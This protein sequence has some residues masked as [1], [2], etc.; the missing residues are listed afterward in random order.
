MTSPD[1]TILLKRM[2]N[3]ISPEYR[4]KYDDEAASCLEQHKVEK[5]K[6]DIEHLEKVNTENVNNPDEKRQF[7]HRKEE[8]EM[9]VH[10][11]ERYSEQNPISPR[12][13]D[14][15][16]T[17]GW[18][19]SII[20][21]RSVNAGLR[22]E[23]T[24]YE[25]HSANGMLDLAKWKE[26]PSK[27]K[28]AINAYKNRSFS[29]C[30]KGEGMKD[31][32]QVTDIHVPRA[33]NLSAV[34]TA[35]PIDRISAKNQCPHDNDFDI[36]SVSGSAN[37]GLGGGSIKKGESKI[38]T[39]PNYGMTGSYAPVGT[40][41]GMWS[42]WDNVR[43]SHFNF[44]GTGADGNCVSQTQTT[45]SYLP[46]KAISSF[47]FANPYGRCI[48]ASHR[49][50]RINS[51][52][53]HFVPH[54]LS[55]AHAFPRVMGEVLPPLTRMNP[56]NAE[57]DVWDEQDA[58]EPNEPIC[59]EDTK[60]EAGDQFNILNFEDNSTE[61]IRTE[62][63]NKAD[64][65]F[66]ILNFKDMTHTGAQES[67]TTR[68]KGENSFSTTEVYNIEPAEIE[69]RKKEAGEQFKVLT[70][71]EKVNTDAQE[72]YATRSKDSVFITGASRNQMEDSK[73]EVAERFDFEG[74]V[75]EGK[76]VRKVSTGRKEG[77]SMSTIQEKA[78]LSQES[79]D[80][81]NITDDDS[82]QVMRNMEKSKKETKDSDY[83]ISIR[84][85]SSEAETAVSNSWSLIQGRDSWPSDLKNNPLRFPERRK[86]RNR[87]GN[88][89]LDSLSDSS[90][91][92]ENDNNT[93]IR[94]YTLNSDS[95]V[96]LRGSCSE[97]ERTES[98]SSSVIQESSSGQS[99]S[100][101]RSNFFL[102]ERNKRYNPAEVDLDSL[103]DS[104][105]ADECGGST[106][107]AKKL[108]ILR[109]CKKPISRKRPLHI[110]RSLKD[111]PE[112]FS[113]I[114]PPPLL[115]SMGK[116]ILKRKREEL[117]TNIGMKHNYNIIYRAA[118]ALVA[119]KMYQ[120]AEELCLDALRDWYFDAQCLMDT[121]ESSCFIRESHMKAVEDISQNL[122][123]L[124]C[125]Y[126]Q[127][128]LKRESRNHYTNSKS[129]C[130]DKMQQERS[131]E[132]K[133][134]TDD[135]TVGRDTV[136]IKQCTATQQDDPETKITRMLC[137]FAVLKEASSC[138]LAGRCS[139]LWLACIHLLTTVISNR[140]NEFSD[141]DQT[142][143]LSF[144]GCS[145]DSK[146]CSWKVVLA[147]YAISLCQKG[148]HVL[149]D[150]IDPP[151]LQNRVQ[152]AKEQNLPFKGS[153]KDCIRNLH[154]R[155]IHS[156]FS[157]EN[158]K[159]AL[160]AKLTSFE[161]RCV[162]KSKLHHIK[163][164]YMEM[165]NLRSFCPISKQHDS[166]PLII[167]K[168]DSEF[169][170]DKKLRTCE[171]E[172]ETFLPL[173][174]VDFG[175]KA[176]KN[177]NHGRC[178][179]VG[180][181]TCD[182]RNVL[183]AETLEADGSSVKTAAK[184]SK[185][186]HTG[187]GGVGCLSA[188]P[189]ARQLIGVLPPPT[190]DMST[191]S[192]S[193]ILSVPRNERDKS[194][195]PWPKIGTI[196]GTP[197][198]TTQAPRPICPLDDNTLRKAL[199]EGPG[200][201]LDAL[202]PF[203]RGCLEK[204]ATNEDE[205]AVGNILIVKGTSVSPRSQLAVT[206]APARSPPNEVTDG[207]D[208]PVAEFLNSK[209]STQE[210]EAGVDGPSVGFERRE[211]V[212]KK[213]C[214]AETS[215]VKSKAPFF[216]EI[217]PT[218][219]PMPLKGV[220]LAALEPESSSS[221][222][223]LETRGI[224][225]NQTLQGEELLDAA[226][227]ASSLT[228]RI[229]TPVEDVP[230]D[231]L[232]DITAKSKDVGIE[233][234]DTCTYAGMVEAIVATG[235]AI[236]AVGVKTL[237]ALK[238]PPSGFDV[239]VGCSSAPV[240]LVSAQ[241]L[242]HNVH[243][244]RN[245]KVNGDG[246]ENSTEPSDIEF[247]TSPLNP[248]WL[249]SDHS[250]KGTSP[251]R[252][253]NFDKAERTSARL[254]TQLVLLPLPMKNVSKQSCLNNRYR[255][256]TKPEEGLDAQKNIIV[257]EIADMT[258][259]KVVTAKV[260]EV[261]DNGETVDAVVMGTEIESVPP[262][263]LSSMC[264]DSERRRA[265]DEVNCR[266]KSC[267]SDGHDNCGEKLR[268]VQ[269]RIPA[270]NNRP[271]SPPSPRDNDNLAERVSE[272]KQSFLEPDE[273]TPKAIQHDPAN[274]LKGDIYDDGDVKNDKFDS[275]APDKKATAERNIEIS[276]RSTAIE[277]GKTR[278]KRGASS[279]SEQCATNECLKYGNEEGKP[280]RND[281][282]GKM[283]DMASTS[284]SN[285]QEAGQLVGDWVCLKCSVLMSTSTLRCKN[286]LHWKR[287]KSPKK[288]R[289]GSP[290]K[291]K[292]QGSPGKEKAS[293]AAALLV[294][295]TSS[296]GEGKAQ[297]TGNKRCLPSCPDGKFAGEAVRSVL[298]LMPGVR[299]TEGRRQ[300]SEGIKV[301][302]ITLG[303]CTNISLRKVYLSCGQENRTIA[304]M[305]GQHYNKSD[306]ELSS[307][308]RSLHATG[309]SK[310]SK[311]NKKTTEHVFRGITREGKLIDSFQD[312]RVDFRSCF[313]SLIAECRA[314][315]DFIMKCK[316]QI[317]KSQTSVICGSEEWACNLCH[318][319]TFE[320]FQQFKPYEHLCTKCRPSKK[321]GEFRNHD[322]HNEDAY[323]VSWSGSTPFQRL[324]PCEPI[325]LPNEAKYVL[326]FL[327]DTFSVTEDNFS[328]QSDFIASKP[329]MKYRKSLERSEK[330][331]EHFS[332]TTSR[333]PS[334]VG[335]VG[336]RCHFC[337]KQSPDD[338]SNL[339]AYPKTCRDIYRAIWRLQT[340]HL[341]SCENIPTDVRTRYH[342][343]QHI[344]KPSA[345]LYQQLW[346][347]VALEL[348][349]E[350][351]AERGGVRWCVY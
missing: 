302:E 79:D 40:G 328:L 132:T 236:P 137:A 244:R 317:K 220:R 195:S 37:S 339:V 315:K 345:S 124:W 286:C 36:M 119:T 208:L 227:T 232:L 23:P 271:L 111:L 343:L 233:V 256:V 231:V 97:L 154:L 44:I 105:S 292:R 242:P 197:S 261:A 213:Y 108:A 335:Q 276:D 330:S 340:F 267:R 351:D 258:E 187:N 310:E 285:G 147:D 219:T 168:G 265:I 294:R 178:L 288:G 1:V 283:R 131:A 333:T 160:Q 50:N 326:E 211:L 161:S 228:V 63:N 162:W 308:A 234:A 33:D 216:K 254:E 299:H 16:N 20:H 327:I 109:R 34:F 29:V 118:Q 209:E 61:P 307:E 126:A 194:V 200:D 7:L 121:V 316:C 93:D 49:Q 280:S 65:L 251:G 85:H 166:L 210:G 247:R 14:M 129:G 138:P 192:T 298:S 135:K 243:K 318:V 201:N 134:G 284:D 127:I 309:M 60:G 102:E 263:C 15:R 84:G 92:I 146:E 325:F 123:G 128:I 314:K 125:V 83:A 18:N 96:S 176:F 193:S 13:L 88:M 120:S 190:F 342:A 222:D 221:D 320:S 323:E 295:E 142:T 136:S 169:I 278:K 12:M 107:R 331:T 17:L 297:Q 42:P 139:W 218:V 87:P 237:K 217:G 239:S 349:L 264:R 282:S 191:E 196:N 250:C 300:R 101:N 110:C 319:S 45:E 301:G 86:K 32:K 177:I 214:S 235:S 241:M 95:S 90:S 174:A 202:G 133:D 80:C 212:M 35:A 337:Q 48:N 198:S 270:E 252:T 91:A 157:F 30:Q 224:I 47:S 296:P 153:N 206:A 73:E 71:E 11:D 223:G 347:N 246:I 78:I 189:G 113:T 151:C 148:L 98:D 52:T 338:L 72:L 89:D 293:H 303:N 226:V 350:D 43:T 260:A 3:E 117:R 332:A 240:V 170:F 185:T 290:G 215:G 2:W 269:A 114:D 262:A 257:A 21:G 8:N 268:K 306:I 205:E 272:E 207:D 66:D 99:I 159:N 55:T 122:A 31:S 180:K 312:N 81:L 164:L 238:M 158:I 163:M 9:M 144:V 230:Q 116:D 329:W 344:I 74:T 321:L 255:K 51:Y 106:L 259:L 175:E 184:L 94:A 4:K 281:K 46:P 24:K 64:E 186:L 253:L 245:N 322:R 287:R 103:S 130:K 179:D 62:D 145:V 167:N 203:G 248:N 334:F 149:S 68:G 5:V 70:L 104:S 53:Q 204:A 150:E 69:D 38:N 171:K 183:M 67:N 76:R 22:D 115:F 75:V 266:G 336:F 324:F 311:T 10:L 291:D 28:Y 172:K 100:Q 304:N 41:P 279:K 56:N 82:S 156:H 58:A 346:C 348:G 199:T 152:L 188:F 155:P 274:S 273:V 173:L 112:K 165:N 141:M 140:H 59:T 77:D 39:Y 143:F 225:G 289:V 25:I 305:L 6:W 275:S 229:V 341:E 57:N 313:A 27:E 26:Q 277:T 54:S 182:K 181:S 19:Q 249:F